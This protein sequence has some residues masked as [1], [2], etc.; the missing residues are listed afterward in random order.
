MYRLPPHPVCHHTSSYPEG[1]PTNRHY[2]YCFT[3]FDTSTQYCKR[4]T[5]RDINTPSLSTV[6][7]PSMRNAPK[8]VPSAPQREV[9]PCPRQSPVHLAIWDG[10]KSALRKPLSNRLSKLGKFTS[11]SKTT[12]RHTW[13]PRLR[14]LDSITAFP[15]FPL[16]PY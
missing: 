9:D 5:A 10:T 6:P 2:C 15:F 11:D 8:A 4:S 16:N 13:A 7:L 1:Y 14:D 3:L 12:K